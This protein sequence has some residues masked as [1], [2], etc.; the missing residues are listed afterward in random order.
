MRTLDDAVEKVI[1][2][3]L[4]GELDL[5]VQVDSAPVPALRD[6]PVEDCSGPMLIIDPQQKNAEFGRDTGPGLL[7]QAALAQHAFEQSLAFYQACPGY[8]CSQTMSEL[9]LECRFPAQNKAVIDP[10]I[11]SE[12]RALGSRPQVLDRAELDFDLARFHDGRIGAVEWTISFSLTTPEGKNRRDSERRRSS[13]R[14][15][16]AGRNTQIA[17]G[18]LDSARTATNNRSSSGTNN[19][20]RAPGI[21]GTCASRG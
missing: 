3:L 14:L 17:A 15:H 4:A 2:M 20:V 8:T 13:D 5:R 21:V 6:D 16:E 9:T 19:E 18:S 12:Q 11:G 10:E 1:G 7:L